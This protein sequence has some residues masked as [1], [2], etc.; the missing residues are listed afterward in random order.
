LLKESFG[1]NTEA[2]TGTPV[3]ALGAALGI[4]G[5][6][7][8]LNQNWSTN[9]P[10]DDEWPDF[11]ATLITANN[12]MTGILDA[13]VFDEEFP[14][15]YE[16]KLSEAVRLAMR[17]KSIDF[18][19]LPEGSVMTGRRIADLQKIVAR[20]IETRGP[21]LG[22]RKGKK[23]LSGL[24]ELIANELFFIFRRQFGSPEVLLLFAHHFFED[25][26]AFIANSSASTAGKKQES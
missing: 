1:A 13:W 22:G 18:S 7:A 6:M 25:I 21:I 17:G 26:V 11:V 24:G 14:K 10:L 8:W 16:G 20:V 12:N 9:V 15:G 4:F 2:V 5:S 23:S 19:G 3:F